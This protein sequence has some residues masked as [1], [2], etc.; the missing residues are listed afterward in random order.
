MVG[1]CAFVGFEHFLIFDV[2]RQKAQRCANQRLNQ[3]ASPS[4]LAR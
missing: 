1:L 3:Q 4:Y 2:V